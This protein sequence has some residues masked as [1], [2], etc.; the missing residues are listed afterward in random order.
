MLS[1]FPYNLASALMA[2]CLPKLRKKSFGLKQIGNLSRRFDYKAKHL[3]TLIKPLLRREQFSMESHG[4][5]DKFILNKSFDNPIFSD[6]ICYKSP[7]RR[8]RG[9][10][11]YIKYILKRENNNFVLLRIFS[12]LLFIYRHSN[13]FFTKTNDFLN[14]YIFYDYS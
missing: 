6:N 13:V 2:I 5:R 7:A 12:E 1:A 9:C 11:L 8:K 4:Y 14:Y 3:L 10:V